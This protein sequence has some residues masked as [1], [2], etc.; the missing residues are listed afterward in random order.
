MDFCGPLRGSSRP[1]T[2]RGGI[3]LVISTLESV[4][5][6][7][8]DCPENGVVTGTL[9]HPPRLRKRSQIC[10]RFRQTCD[11]WGDGQGGMCLKFRQWQRGLRTYSIWFRNSSRTLQLRPNADPHSHVRSWRRRLAAPGGSRGFLRSPAWLESAGDCVEV[12]FVS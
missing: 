6:C 5:W 4:E 10:L 9:K 11:Q 7:C 3:G 8:T 2:V 1:E 12:A